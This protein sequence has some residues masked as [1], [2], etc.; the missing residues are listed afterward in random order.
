MGA[1]SGQRNDP[2]WGGTE[3][4]GNEPLRMNALGTIG[5]PCAFG[6]A[7]LG[8]CSLRPLAAL[9]LAEFIRNQAPVCVCACGVRAFVHTDICAH[10]LVCV[11]MYHVVCTHAC[12]VHVCVAW[13]CMCVCSDL[14]RASGTPFDSCDL[15]RGP[16]LTAPTAT[17]TVIGAVLPLSLLC[18]FAVC[19]K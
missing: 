19:E 9:R 10:M 15:P 4:S 12:S 16:G 1:R 18:Q 14:S 13:M 8:L 17:H 11:Y 3:N 7:R 6:K 5:A 2:F